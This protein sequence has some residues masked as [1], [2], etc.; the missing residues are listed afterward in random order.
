MIDKPDSDFRYRVVIGRY[1]ATWHSMECRIGALAKRARRTKHTP[2]SNRKALTA[3]FGNA[4]WFRY[5]EPRMAQCCIGRKAKEQDRAPVFT[6]Q[7]AA[8]IFRKAQAAGLAAGNAAK[9]TAMV[10]G[11]PK[12]FLGDEIDYTKR[13]YYVSE[14][15]CGFAWVTIRPGNSSLARHARR[16]GIGGRAYGGGVRIWVDE[17]NQSM[18]RKE[19]HA[20]AFADVLREHGVEAY[21]QSR[22]D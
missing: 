5:E 10:V 1:Q 3:K 17:Y 8:K 20:H 9:P 2:E 14:G 19:K 7:E 21:A 13:T 15:V 12:N 11:T 22:M 6:K 16:L 18:E 4:P